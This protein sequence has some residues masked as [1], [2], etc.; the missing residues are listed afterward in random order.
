MRSLILVAAAMSL[1]ACGGSGDD[2]LGD[3]AADA[4]EARADNL[5]SAAENASGDQAD[6]LEDQADATERNG[7]RTEEAIDDSDVDAG[8]LSEGQ[9][10]AL[11]N[12]Q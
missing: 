8:E 4:A 10:N 3:E 7:E 12:G 11:V 5:E 9:R 6:N 1:A 2:K